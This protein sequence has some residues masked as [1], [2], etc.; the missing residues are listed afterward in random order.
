MGVA[1]GKKKKPENA[2]PSDYRCDRPQ[3]YDDDRRL[4][5]FRRGRDAEGAWRAEK[6]TGAVRRRE[7]KTETRS[8]GRK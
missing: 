2:R 3:E 5:H 6:R 8:H 1:R 4:N 7:S